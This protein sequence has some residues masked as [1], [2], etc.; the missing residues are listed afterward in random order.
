MG[1]L[2]YLISNVIH[3]YAVSVF[4]DAFLG[5]SR[6]NHKLK[7]VMYLVYYIFGSLCW[8]FI[9]SSTLN[10]AFNIFA[11]F[12]ITIQYNTSL[13][14]KV[15]SVIS[16]QATAMFIEWIAFT[17]FENS[18]AVRTGIVQYIIILIVAFLFKRIY[19][20]NEDYSSKSKYS[21]LLIL[22]AFGTVA[23]GVLTVNDDSTHDYVIAV[24]LLLINLMN[25]YI[26]NLEQKSLESQHTLELIETSNN[27]Y[28]TQIQIMN[29]TQKKLR[30]I[31]HDFKNHMNKIRNLIQNENYQKI[32]EYL[33]EMEEAVT[34]K[35]EFSKTGNKDV[36]SLINYELTI[37]AEFG[38]EIICNIE[39]PNELNVTSF[40]MT[41]ILGNLLNNAVE[42]LRQTERKVLIITVKFNKGV[43]RIDIEN[44]YDAKY[45][46][47]P[48]GREHGIGLMSVKNTLEKY[49]GSIKTFPEDNKYHTTVVLFN[50]LE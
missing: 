44:S 14:K 25:F 41:V 37:A 36:D 29:E 30:F 28:K 4:L 9:H 6:L 13:K 43:I 23:I 12:F 31:R 39:L 18:E 40:D 21:W 49:H 35:S 32:Q 50:S 46:R 33:D 38:T 16:S 1:T 26:Y 2:L 20:R 27:A 42:A 47:K 17:L 48:D 11:T 5:N 8:I 15:F 34:V 3:I 10:I 24:I 45:K 22:M 19:V 7:S